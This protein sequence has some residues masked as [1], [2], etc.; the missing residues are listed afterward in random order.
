M[1][2]S[3]A[4]E[5]DKNEEMP[6]LEGERLVLRE[7]REPDAES[8]FKIFGDPDV[9]L[10]WSSPAQKLV[11]E[12]RELILDARKQFESRKL[13]EWGVA[14]RDTDEVIGTCTLLNIDLR[15]RRAEIG[16]ALARE[17]WRKGYATEALDLAL[18]F[19]FGPMDLHRLEADVHPENIGSFRLLE[20]QGFKR[21]GYLRERWHHLGRIE[22]GVFLGLLRP[23]WLE[24]K[25]SA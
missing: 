6:R 4:L 9:I 18:A 22:D 25:Q 20:K 8:V 19:A 2:V 24:L 1:K 12:A 13:I 11:S 7:M 16:Y 10:Y 3:K 14:L 5:F 15:H 23:E 21:E 17:H